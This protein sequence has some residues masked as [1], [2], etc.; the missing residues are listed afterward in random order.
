[1]PTGKMYSN[2]KPEYFACE[3][4][5]IIQSQCFGIKPDIDVLFKSNFGLAKY[6]FKVNFVLWYFTPFP[7]KLY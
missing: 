4:N 6:N 2:R 1:M 3:I 7:N 5:H